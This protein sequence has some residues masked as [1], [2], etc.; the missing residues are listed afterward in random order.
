MNSLEPKKLAL[1]RILQI[2]HD[3]SDVNHPL[4]QED[5]AKHLLNDYGIDMER[6]AISNNIALL[7][8]YAGYDIVSEKRGSYLDSRK[9]EDSELKLLIDSVLY[10]KYIAPKYA[11]DLIEKLS[12]FGSRSF[13]KKLKTGYILDNFH[14][15]TFAEFF[16]N[17]DT[18]EEA[19]QNRVQVKFMLN[20]YGED[21]KLH[22]VRDEKIAV[23]P[24]RIIAHQGEY[25]LI[26]SYNDDDCLVNLHIKFITDIEL[27]DLPSKVFEDMEKGNVSI[28]DYINA[29]PYMYNGR[30]VS[31]KMRVSRKIFSDL[32]EAFGKDFSVEEIA[33]ERLSEFYVN[34]TL[35]ANSW[36][37]RRFALNYMGYVTV[38]SPEWIVKKIKFYIQEGCK[39]YFGEECAEAIKA[40]ASKS[41]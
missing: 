8:D 26:C 30:M 6:K 37:I 29:H 13:A 16:N 1:L 22:P 17:I 7:R 20:E 40:A 39:D 10:S 28:T 23:N 19:I 33:D 36:D 34:V 21:K 31:V 18:I 4:T 11:K 38:L 32:I 5:I 25:Y 12:T 14:E 35:R 27:T 15:R 41:D 2:L 24:Y 9:F 3:C